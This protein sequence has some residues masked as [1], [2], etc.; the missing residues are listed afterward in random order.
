MILRH[1]SFV[2]ATK[3]HHIHHTHFEA[4]EVQTIKIHIRTLH[5]LAV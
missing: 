2:K 3:V 5:K 1:I 4:Y